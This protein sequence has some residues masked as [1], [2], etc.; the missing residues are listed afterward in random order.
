MIY[1]KVSTLLP[2]CTTLGLKRKRCGE[3][4]ACQTDDCGGCKFCKDKAK[5]GGPN[6]LKQCCIKRRCLYKNTSHSDSP[7]GSGSV[8]IEMVISTCVHCTGKHVYLFIGIINVTSIKNSK[9][10]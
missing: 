8:K 5:F 3:C 9:E 2:Q 4:E 1:Y 7:L 10:H 6:K